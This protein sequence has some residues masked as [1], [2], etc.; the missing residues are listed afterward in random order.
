[1]L[2]ELKKYA[3]NFLSLLL[4]GRTAVGKKLL[5]AFD[6]SRGAMQAVNFV[7]STMGSSDFIGRVTN[8]VIHMARGRTVW[9]VR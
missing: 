7:G 9:V 2:G 3:R 6:G 8:K 5:L 1:M 4:A